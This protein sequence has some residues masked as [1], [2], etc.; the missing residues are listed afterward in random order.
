MTEHIFN[1]FILAYL[2]I[3]RPEKFATL[4]Y[5]FRPTFLGYV[6]NTY[7]PRKK[8]HGKKLPS[9]IEVIDID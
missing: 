1:D 5:F 9:N 4:S 6:K 8:S 7:L 2:V 3:F